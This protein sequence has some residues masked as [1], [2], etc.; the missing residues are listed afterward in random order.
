MHRLRPV[1]FRPYPRTSYDCDLLALTLYSRV[2]AHVS[3]KEKM[4]GGNGDMQMSYWGLNACALVQNNGIYGTRSV[5][6]GLWYIFVVKRP[7]CFDA[8]AKDVEDRWCELSS[9]V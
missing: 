2:D 4:L 3:S 6:V 8:L 1:R 5:Q 9:N 7:K